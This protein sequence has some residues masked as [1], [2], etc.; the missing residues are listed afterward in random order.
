APRATTT[1][2]KA[3]FKPSTHLAVRLPASHMTLSQAESDREHDAMAT[4]LIIGASRGIGLEA[5]KA[6]LAAG[7][8]VRALARSAR[9]TPFTQADTARGGHADG[10]P[11]RQ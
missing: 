11:G 5:V 6:A 9:R 4:V 7:H 8:S 10:W 1:A 2:L 3:R